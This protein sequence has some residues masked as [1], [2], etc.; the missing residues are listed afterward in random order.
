MKFS[1]EQ[2]L[3]MVFQ[4]EAAECGLA[5]LAM[6]A[7]YHGLNVDLPALRK[8]FTLSLRGTTLNHIIR[9]AGPLI[10]RG[11]RCAW[12]WKTLTA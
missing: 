3:P 10:S 12:S 11:V 5:C 2:K 1:R 7:G 6:I 4:T 8:R 9:F